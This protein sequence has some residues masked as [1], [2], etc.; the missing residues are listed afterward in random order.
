MMLFYHQMSKLFIDLVSVIKMQVYTKKILYLE[1]I[2]SLSILM[3]LGYI[4]FLA[5]QNM[6][7]NIT[8]QSE[9]AKEISHLKDLQY[10]NSAIAL[11]IYKTSFVN[12]KSTESFIDLK[13]NIE[14]YYHLID[15]QKIYILRSDFKKEFPKVYKEIR[16]VFSD[17]EKI[18][19]LISQ[20]YFPLLKQR[21]DVSKY[22][23]VINST[24]DANVDNLNIILQAAEQHVTLALEEMHGSVKFSLEFSILIFL[25]V[26]VMFVLFLL[27]IN[28][29]MQRPLKELIYSIQTIGHGKVNVDALVKRKDAFSL[30]GKIVK[31]IDIEI[32]KK[33]KLIEE[34]EEILK[35]QA[36]FDALTHL[37]NRFLMQDRL[38]QALREAQRDKSQVGIMFIDL[39]RFKEINDSLG[40]HV[41]DQVLQEV[42][43]RFSETIRK[44]D[45]LA[46]LG[47]DEFTII[48][49]DLDNKD[50]ISCVADKVVDALRVPIKVDE[51]EFYISSSIGISIY[52]DDGKDIETLL[53]HADLAM[54][55]VKNSGRNDF[56]FYEEFMSK[57]SLKKLAMDSELHKALLNEE[58][59]VYYQP[60]LNVKTN[61]LIGMEAL[62]RWRHPDRGIVSPI[63]FITLAEEMG[64]INHIDDWVCKNVCEQIVIWQKQGLKPVRVA[65][66]LSGKQLQ[67]DDLIETVMQTLKETACE[68]R[69]LSLEVTEG[70][71]MHDHEKSIKVLSRLR[72]LGI[73]LA[74]DDFGT[75]YSSLSYLKHL[76][77]DKLKID[78]SFIHNITTDYQDRAIVK[79]IVSLSQ[80]M[81]LEVLAEGVETEQQKE[82][83]KQLGCF[84]IQGY[85]YAR[86]LPAKDVVD[87]F[88]LNE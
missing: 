74:I 20:K 23:Y 44:K 73:S 70:F 85:L 55:E 36:H 71:I 56:Q 29:R 65:V 12:E 5:M 53:R 54:Y 37:P 46:R 10:F 17:L 41:G 87:F 80:S 11:D 51:H 18:R 40:H 75:G 69:Y 3:I 4:G 2:I 57:D 42:S 31:Q 58:F 30:L 28:K 24:L 14:D 52:P 34:N 64:I 8:L 43:L 48:I 26:I 59:V 47:G 39:D 63:E 60:Q 21:K 38:E 35:H 84:E 83:L 66:N 50:D 16:V 45:T 7:K 82:F 86:P 33:T 79:T 78:R 61:E 81:H 62:V 27:F 13:D 72:D 77:V 68:A 32:F 1:F 88:L 22:L 25:I 9:R 67:R 15:Q 19:D 76:P 49:N 6:T